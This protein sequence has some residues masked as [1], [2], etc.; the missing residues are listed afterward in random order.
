MTEANSSLP[1]PVG[2][3]SCDP[4]NVKR[5]RDPLSALR[6]LG[7]RAQVREF[8]GRISLHPVPLALNVNLTHPQL[9][10]KRISIEKLSESS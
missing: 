9:P 2:L 3:T 5:T 7:L 4:D 6:I 1:R 8:G 10:E